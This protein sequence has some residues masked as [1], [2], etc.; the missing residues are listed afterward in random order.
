[1]KKAVVMGVLSA[2]T[3]L[4]GGEMAEP[5]AMVPGLEV[6]RCEAH[7]KKRADA[8]LVEVDWAVEVVANK[9]RYADIFMAE[10]TERAVMLEFSTQVPVKNF[11]LLRL[12]FSRFNEDDMPVFAVEALYE[13]DWLTPERPLAAGIAFYGTIPHYGFSY[14]DEQGDDKYFS[15]Y[16]SG[17]DGSLQM[18][19]FV[20]ERVPC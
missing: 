15:V 2:L 9:R 13:R 7:H 8:G 1:M 14:E 17:Y 19:E 6:R 11:R 10:P 4:A 3:V 12:E 20:A 16:E 18:S 5:L